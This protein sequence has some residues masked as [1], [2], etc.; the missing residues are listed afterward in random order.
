MYTVCNTCGYHQL[1]QSFG[2]AYCT[3]YMYMFCTCT[4]S[5]QTMFVCLRV[6]LLFPLILVLICPYIYMYM[7]STCTCTVHVHV[8]Y[9][10][11]YS[12]C[13]LVSAMIQISTCS[14]LYMRVHVISF[15][16][17]VATSNTETCYM[18]TVCQIV[19]C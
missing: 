12:T 16:L 18:Y 6:P 7:Y 8:L 10:Y 4:Y 15:F 19:C 5:N 1:L 14:I 11:M 13:I 17:S 3:S 2:I 9:M